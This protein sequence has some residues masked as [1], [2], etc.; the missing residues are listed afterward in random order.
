MRQ[1]IRTEIKHMKSNY[2]TED[3]KQKSKKLHEISDGGK[4]NT[5]FVVFL[6][7]SV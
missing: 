7:I 5:S 4:V 2:E 1:E 3:Q 6:S